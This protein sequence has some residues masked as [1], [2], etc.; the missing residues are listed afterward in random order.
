MMTNL[1][2]MAVY[3]KLAFQ[4][5]LGEVDQLAR[6]LQLPVPVP[7]QQQHVVDAFVGAPQFGVNGS[8]QISN[9]AFTFWGGRLHTITRRDVYPPLN[10]TDET[11][12]KLPPT[13]NITANEAYQLATQW[14]GAISMD[15]A[16]LERQFSKK[17]SQE[18]Y[19][20]NSQS[21]LVPHGRNPSH[22]DPIRTTVVYVKITWGEA[23]QKPYDPRPPVQVTL[24]G[25]TKELI[26]LQLANRS[27]LQ[28]PLIVATNTGFQV[29]TNL[30]ELFEKPP[31]ALQP[32]PQPTLHR[33]PV[34][35]PWAYPPWAPSR[36]LTPE[37]LPEWMAKF[38]GGEAAMQTLTHPERVNVYTLKKY[39]P[40]AQK[41]TAENLVP[42]LKNFKTAAD[43]PIRRG[44][45]PVTI[46]QA[47]ELGQILAD[48]FSYQ[49]HWRR[50][51]SDEPYI[52]HGVRYDLRLEFIR[53]T[54]AVDVIFAVG[55]PTLQ[56]YSSTRQP[57]LSPEL[58]FQPRQEDVRKILKKISP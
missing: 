58:C 30:A 19:S 28:R 24:L 47:E 31:P 37:Q 34:P 26:D 18:S 32:I 52:K 42:I 48:A 13:A 9:V 50:E 14:L 38:F 51:V 33:T 5:L 56:F 57:I 21:L 55:E 35:E 10:M 44:P 20:A 29:N 36:A 11:I 40:I 8:L 2:S 6:E 12:A 46:S 27:F 4:L 43:F 41:P 7:I 45:I 54:N 23:W 25:N 49:W 15:V 22:R 17:I 3:Q 16:A 39:N 1:L 53:Q